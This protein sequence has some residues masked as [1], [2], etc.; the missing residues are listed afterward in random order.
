MEDDKKNQSDFGS[1]NA[2]LK[3]KLTKLTFE[4]QFTKLEKYNTILKAE[5]LQTNQHLEKLYSDTEKLDEQIMTQRPKGDMSGIGYYGGE[6]SKKSEV[7]EES[8]LVIQ[9]PEQQQ[10]DLNKEVPKQ[11]EQ[12]KEVKRQFNGRCITCIKI[13]HMKKNYIGKYTNPCYGYFHNSYAYGH[14]ANECSK[15][16]YNKHY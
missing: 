5:L 4:L 3:S 11:S 14:R 2:N 1:K 9:Q 12:P 10:E 8:D 13:G 7:T 16:I 6:S 15:T